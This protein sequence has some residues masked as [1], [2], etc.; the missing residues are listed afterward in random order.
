MKFQSVF[1][2]VLI[3]CI[4]SC[5]IQS[6]KQDDVEPNIGDADI[7]SNSLEILR[8]ENEHKRRILLVQTDSNH[9]DEVVCLE[10]TDTT[11]IS[12]FRQYLDRKYVREYSYGHVSPWDY[13]LW[14]GIGDKS[15]LYFVK[16]NWKTDSVMIVKDGY[17]GYASMS[18]LEWSSYIQTFR[19]VYQKKYKILN[20]KNAKRVYQYNSANNI[21]AQYQ[22]DK[23]GELSEKP[24][25]EWLN[26]EGFFKYYDTIN[27]EDLYGNKTLARLIALY[28]NDKF[29]IEISTVYA[30]LNKNE[31]Q[32]SVTV[33]GNKQF[34]NKFQSQAIVSEW[35]PI[36]IFMTVISDKE[37]LSSIDSIIAWQSQ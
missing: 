27:Y 32:N 37:H 20:L 25:I 11:I 7:R 23:Y 24:N 15:C 33:F 12:K 4:Y 28:P 9:V 29:S 14:L 5:D 8:V 36:E 13:S 34:F 31:Y 19:N 26:Y 21:A 17:Q 10:Q 18:K 35:K 2:C 3:I 30:D 1:I 6:S 22:I 16:T